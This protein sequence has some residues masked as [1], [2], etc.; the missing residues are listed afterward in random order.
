MLAFESAGILGFMAAAA[1][2]LVQ[3]EP[4][5]LAAGYAGH[6]FWDLF[7]HRPRA[8]TAEVPGWYIPMCLGYDLIVAAYVIARFA[9]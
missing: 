1:V 5:L 3:D 8:A 6:A 4:W 7:H 9:L 2:A